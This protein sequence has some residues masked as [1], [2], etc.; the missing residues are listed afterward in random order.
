MV[1]IDNIRGNNL[2]VNGLVEA[3]YPEGAAYRECTITKVRFDER[4]FGHSLT[5]ISL[6][7]RPVIVYSR[8]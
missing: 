8:V 1:S 5:C 6:G 7:A 4:R 3:R 2:R